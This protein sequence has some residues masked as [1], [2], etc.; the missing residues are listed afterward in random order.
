MLAHVNFRFPE[1][2]TEETT[3]AN[4]LSKKTPYEKN[5][6][7]RP[8]LGGGMSGQATRV[9]CRLG[10]SRHAPAATPKAGKLA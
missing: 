10:Q 7:K 2:L 8:L 5:C 4:V 9:T 6:Q 1:F 3:C